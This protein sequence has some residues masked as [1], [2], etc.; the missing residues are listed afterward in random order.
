M[1]TLLNKFIC[2]MFE[3]LNILQFN[4]R[5]KTKNYGLG[6]NMKLYEVLSKLKNEKEFETFFEDLCTFQ[7]VEKMEQR[8]ECAQMLLDGETYNQIIEKTD[9]SSA[10][11]SRVSRCIQHGSGGYSKILK[12]IMQKKAEGDNDY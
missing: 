6:D 7:E 4:F 11:L 9:I 2:K 3:L 12:D 10:T 8:V 5:S 1:S